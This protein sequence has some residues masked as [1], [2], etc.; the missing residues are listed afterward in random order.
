MAQGLSLDVLGQSWPAPLHHTDTCSLPPAQRD[1]EREW[2]EQENVWV[3]I[4][5]NM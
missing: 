5:L 1:R 2:E 4:K 3:K